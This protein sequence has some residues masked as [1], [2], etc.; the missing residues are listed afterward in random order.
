ML[1]F[2]SYYL[3]TPII[4]GRAFDVFFPEEIK[5]K[6]QIFIVHGGGW[7]G[8]SRV[9]FHVIMEKLAELGYVCATSDY[10]LNAK[11]AF[12][13][14]SD[15]RDSYTAFVKL[16]EER[17]IAPRIAVYGESAGSH[18][19]SLL[20]Y[21]NAGECGEIYN[22]EWVKPALAILHA[23]PVHFIPYEWMSD[24]LKSCI[25]SI[26]GASYEDAPEVYE[27]LSLSSYVRQDN[28][29]TFFIEAGNE[30]MFP[31]EYTKNI[32]E[33]HNR[34]GIPSFQKIYPNCEHGF[35]YDLTR[36]A[37]REA[38]DDICK[39]IENDESQSL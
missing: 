31:S 26:A 37:Q 16:L 1:K 34:M 30:S 27:R 2:N 38:F 4:K 8:G 7:R 13:Q 25:R 18:L 10:R 32:A 22:G 23:T 39:F 15:L 21:A 29:K 35:F 17:G 12:E 24:T 14:I 19:A 5:H 9:S 36:K 20:C 33:A 6:T 28:P 11:D 3:D